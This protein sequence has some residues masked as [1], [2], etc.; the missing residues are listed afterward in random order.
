MNVVS[1]ANPFEVLW[2]MGY[3]RLCP[4]TPPGCAVHP[5]AIAD[6][7]AAGRDVRGK[8]PGL[9]RGE[10]WD[11][12][13]RF[14]TRIASEADLDRWRSW[15]A[16]VGIVA[17][18]GIIGL[19]AD[20]LREANANICREEIENRIGLLPTRIGR[21]PK[22]LFVCRTDPDFRYDRLLFGEGERV[23]IIAPGKQ[24]VAW[25]VHPGTLRPYS[26]TRRLVPVDELTYASPETLRGLMAALKERLPDAV[27]G[28]RRGDGAAPDQ[29]T[30]RGDL[31]L[32]RRAV[33]AT[34]NTSARFPGRED[35]LDY[36]YALKAALPDNPDEAFALFSRWCADWDEG[37]NDE[38]I[39]AADWARMKPPYRRGASWLYEIAEKQSG[40]SFA[41]ASAWWEESE[42]GDLFPER[43]DDEGDDSLPTTR[44]SELVGEPPAQKW[45]VRDFIPHRCVTLLYGDGGTGKSLAALQLCFAAATGTSWLGMPCDP[46]RSLFITAEDEMDELHRR[47]AA[48]MRGTGFFPSDCDGLHLAS[49]NGQDAVLAA[50]NPKTGLMEPTALFRRVRATIERIRP[51][52]VVLD[53]LAD[54]FGGDEIKRVQARQFIQLLQGLASRADW[55]LSVIVLGHPSVAGMNSGAGSSGSTAWSNS[56]RSRLYLERRYA[57]YNAKPIEVDAD[58]RVL[59]GKKTNRARAGF[60][61]LLRWSEGRFVVEESARIDQTGAADEVAFLALL[62]EFERA[63]RFVSAVPTAAS[64]AP[65]IFLTHEQGAQIGRARL[66]SA[67]TRLFG[68][69]VLS[70]ESYGAPSRGHKKIARKRYE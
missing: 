60:E 4:I 48:I 65:R 8:A 35:Y 11:G 12:D 5:G 28:S 31:D 33:A 14:L 51:G 61:M 19:D 53:T 25:G 34:R 22:A 54:I 44:L 62:D 40:G 47:A 63:D 42:P 55:D 37:E 17:S 30:L 49:L 67:M 66:E 64:Y 20:C 13:S 15:G 59:S 68:Q 39:I 29:S 50:P 43:Y 41:R 24:F 21:A 56:V 26:W 18:E 2:R 46:G 70:I 32:V 1:P 3:R 69:A 6:E 7:L 57:T 27:L 45:L 16:G 52:V 58:V 9:L 23:E 38:E 10:A 36:G